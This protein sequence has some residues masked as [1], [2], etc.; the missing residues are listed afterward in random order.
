M[1]KRICKSVLKS[2][3]AFEPL[4]RFFSIIVSERFMRVKSKRIIMQKKSRKD[5]F[6]VLEISVRFSHVHVRKSYISFWGL[7]NSTDF[8]SEKS[9]W[10][11]SSLNQNNN[12]KKTEQ[13]TVVSKN[14]LE[15]AYH[16]MYICLPCRQVNRM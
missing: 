14:E 1:E 3:Q 16:F 13:N 12:N 6:G 9:H 11:S 8:S 7:S 2:W 10:E 4:S 15:F 5:S